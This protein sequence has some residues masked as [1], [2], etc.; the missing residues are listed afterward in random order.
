MPWFAIRA[1]CRLQSNGGAKAACSLN[2][3]REYRGRCGDLHV[4]AAREPAK[5]RRLAA[6]YE[7]EVELRGR[8]E[9]DP[10]AA[11]FGGQD[12]LGAAYFALG[13][14]LPV[15]RYR[16]DRGTDQLVDYGQARAGGVVAERAAM[17]DGIL[18][19]PVAVV[20]SHENLRAAT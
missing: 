4:K 17:C 14:E 15:D 9:L 6:G 18:E 1:S 2:P 16:V 3:A 8:F 12:A 20:A 19:A 11:A 13:R 10:Q 5:G 7:L